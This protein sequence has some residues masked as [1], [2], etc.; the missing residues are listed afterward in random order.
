MSKKPTQ[1]KK[2]A[3]NASETDQ[4]AGIEGFSMGNSEAIDL[5]KVNK[6]TSKSDASKKEVWQSVTESND[7][8]KGNKTPEFDTTETPLDNSEVDTPNYLGDGLHEDD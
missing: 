4:G 6:K 3:P 1:P 2:N 8:A 5:A 7:L